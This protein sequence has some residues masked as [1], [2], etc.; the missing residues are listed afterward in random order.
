MPIGFEETEANAMLDAFCNGTSYGGNAALYMQLHT[1]GAGPAGTTHVATE[2]RRVH[3]V[4][5]TPAGGVCANTNAPSLT[6]VA[7][8]ETITNVSFWD[9]SSGGNFKGSGQLATALALTAGQTLNVNAGDVTVSLN[10][11]G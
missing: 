11:A 7:A 10:D 1:G 5:G 2:T 3:V 8:T 4:F 6:S 9:A